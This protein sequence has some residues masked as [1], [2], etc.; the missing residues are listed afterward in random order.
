[1]GPIFVSVNTRR[2]CPR[3]FGD[4]HPSCDRRALATRADGTEHLRVV[5]GSS[6]PKIPSANVNALIVM[7]A[8]TIAV[9]IVRSH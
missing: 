3:I 7:A 1:M 2:S 5:D 9:A 6:L 8:E 4:R